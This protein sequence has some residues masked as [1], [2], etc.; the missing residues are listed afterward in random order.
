MGE[1]STGDSETYEATKDKDADGMD[2]YGVLEEISRFFIGVS[3]SKYTPLLLMVTGN[4]YSIL[5]ET[6]MWSR[7]IILTAFLMC[8]IL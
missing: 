7:L 4:M 8:Q 6:R 5:V 1:D 3:N 2:S